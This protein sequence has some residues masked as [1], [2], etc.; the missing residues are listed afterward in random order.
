MMRCCCLA[1]FQGRWG[2][3]E[4]A[5]RDTWV[6]VPMSLL[7]SLT[8]HGFASRVGRSQTCNPVLTCVRTRILVL[9]VDSVG[10]VF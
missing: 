9:P 1:L 6:F 3:R 2:F 4:A 5:L 7:L 10:S 8:G